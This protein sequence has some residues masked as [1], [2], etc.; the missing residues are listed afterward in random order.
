MFNLSVDPI[1]TYPGGGGWD[2][3]GPAREEDEDE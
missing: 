3:P 2:A 1:E